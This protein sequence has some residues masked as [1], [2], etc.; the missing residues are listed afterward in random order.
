MIV[1]HSCTVALVDPVWVGHHAT[2]FRAFIEAFVEAG[3]RVIAVCPQ[4]EAL[5]DLLGTYP[6]TLIAGKLEDPGESR[7]LPGRDHDPF[8]TCR[9]WRLA[10]DA[11]TQLEKQSAWP[12]DF[13]YFAWLDSYLRFMISTGLADRILGRPWTG[14]Y[15]RNQHLTEKSRGLMAKIKNRLKGDF[16]M[17]SSA[18]R[19][20]AGVDER[21]LPHIEAYTGKPVLLMPDITDETPGN[22]EVHLART[23]R[24]RARE[25]KVIGMVGLE[26]RKGF[27]T[28]L[29]AAQ[30]AEAL[31]EPWYFAFTGVLWWNTLTPSEAAWVRKILADPPE[32]IYLDPDAGLVPDG[33]IY[34]G[35]ASTFDVFFAAYLNSIYNGSSNVLTKAALL[36]KP[37][38]VTE[39]ACLE[40]RAAFFRLGLAIP[41]DDAGR[42][43]EAIRALLGGVDWKGNPLEPRYE[44]YFELHS[45][46]KL[47]Q[48]VRIMISAAMVG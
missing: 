10:S 46:E 11:I 39:G 44:D 31:G 43:L 26:K 19:L 4:P 36:R 2:Y 8:L 24:E 33:T 40:E 42:C 30:K 32:N 45:R 22:P 17:R 27:L 13:V 1:S 29:R 14:L 28:L 25:R 16:V 12:V 47:L 38:V 48:N 7:L 3:A 15:F 34:N 23:I 18:C 9:R 21:T 41:E 35:I 37:V 20:L 6:N 5:E